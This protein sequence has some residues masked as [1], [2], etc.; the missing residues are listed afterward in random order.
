MSGHRK[1][2]EDWF[3]QAKLAVVVGTASMSEAE[4]SAWHCVKGTN[5]E[6]VQHWKEAGLQGAGMQSDWD[7]V[8]RSNKR[9]LGKP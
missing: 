5:P 7:R 9:I 3:H 8:V 4:L 1:T 6:Q 2:E